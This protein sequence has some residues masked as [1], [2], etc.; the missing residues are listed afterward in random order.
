M[1][2][3]SKVTIKKRLLAAVLAVFMATAF[4]LPE[5]A[6]AGRVQAA[7]STAEIANVVVFV[8]YQ[9]DAKDIFNATN[10]SYSNWQ[11]IKNMYNL[12][13]DS[14]SNYISA[15]TEGKVHVTN[16][17]PQEQSGGQGVQTLVI[18][19]NGGNGYVVSAVVKALADGRISLNTTDKLDNRQAGILD[20]LTIIVQGNVADP[21]KGESAFKSVYAG[22]EKVNELLIRDYNMIPS[23]KLVL[24]NPGLNVLPQQGVIS[25]EFLHTLGLPDLYRNSNSGSGDPVGKWDIMASVSCFLQYPLSYLRA[26]Q[27]WIPMKTID[28]SGTYTLTAVSESGG[29]KVF[30][31]KTPLSDSELICLEYRKQ[32]T[33]PNRFDHRIP[34]SGLLMYRVDNKVEGLTNN[35][36]KNYIYVYRPRVTHPEAAADGTTDQA[37]LDVSK[38]ETSY[39]T[40][41]LNADFTQDTLYYSDGS[42]SGIRISDLELSADQN[43]LT[44]TVT[45]ADYSQFGVWDRLDGGISGQFNGEP[46]ICIDPA[47]GTIYAAYAESLSGNISATQVRVMRWNGTGWQQVGAT[48]DNAQQPALAVCGGEVY[49]S[50]RKGDWKSV[51][52]CKL[53]GNAWGQV[54]TC[55]AQYPGSMQFVVDGNEIYGAFQEESGNNKRLVIF[56]V[57]GRKL[58]TNSLTASGTS[59]IPGDFS[60]PAVVKSGN[61]FYVAC[62]EFPSGSAQIREYNM[63]TGSWSTA[64]TIA[65][66]CTNTHAIVKQGQKIYAFAGRTGTPGSSEGG[67]ACMAMFDGNSWS[68]SSVTSM[69][70]FNWVSMDVLEGQVYLAYYDTTAKKARLLRGTGTVLEQYSD[71]LGIGLDF[72][73]IRG[74][75]DSIYA[76]VKAENTGTMVV[77]RKVV[78]ESSVT[79]P[80]P[81][82]PRMLTLTPPAGYGDNTIYV[83]GVEYAAKKTGNSYQVEL[84]DTLGK[85]AVMYSYNSSNIPV[86][87]YVW[88]LEWNG[89]TCTAVPLPGLQDMLSYHG[90]SIR[91]QSPA[92]IR[93]KSGIDAGLKQQLITTGVDGCVLKEYGTLF[94]TNENREKYPF[95]KGGTK[96]GGGRAYWTENG[97]VN[98]KVFETVSGRNRFTSVLINLAPNMY[99]KDISFRA[100]A[101]LD[102]GG[103]EI[104]VYGP[105]VYR[106]VYTVAKQVQAKGEFKVGSS[107]YNYVQGIIDS[108]EGR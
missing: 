28:K 77:R 54:A 86:G 43:K 79:P 90:F 47:T 31:L 94:I 49:L 107:G 65:N 30:V 102:C 100:Y 34:T 91:V 23:A 85:T 44:F 76:A 10:G 80:T 96:V 20:N 61:S 104:I 63:S 62:A 99:A 8:K 71:Q 106:S 21:D 66:V 5:M 33:D 69:K 58:V 25:H 41:D 36:G 84:P 26:R 83:D 17:F 24:E 50:Y 70:Q 48:I 60:N 35:A 88:K 13:Q 89:Q 29:D 67:T 74:Y 19:R 1:K 92:G 98:D 11:M 64:Y 4:P 59:M 52:Y 87:M 42:N 2:S 101:V 55:A 56:D 7:G 82:N 105:P 18:P 27:G 15:V 37:A 53:S 45:F 103:Q 73:Q 75:G 57:K 12:D 9:D 78:T 40:I 95:V 93:F 22:S 39:G 6:S 81:Q 14:F 51:V 108:V 16:Y 3:P 97:V 38:G 32:A 68:S 46:D 72:L